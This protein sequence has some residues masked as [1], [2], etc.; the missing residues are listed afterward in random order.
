MMNATVS[1]TEIR[2]IPGITE[3]RN[4]PGIFEHLKGFFSLQSRLVPANM[5][6][7]SSTSRRRGY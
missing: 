1:E 2:N 3:I 5:D 7:I 4:I 6:S